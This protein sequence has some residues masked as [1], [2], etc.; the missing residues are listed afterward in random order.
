MENEKFE[1]SYI[2]KISPEQKGN[3]GAKTGWGDVFE[4]FKH[5]SVIFQDSDE[6]RESVR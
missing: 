4:I 2:K 5:Q 6:S 3:S 1:K